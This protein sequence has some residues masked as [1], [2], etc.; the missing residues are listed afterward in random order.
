MDTIKKIKTLS[1]AS[2]CMSVCSIGYCAYNF[3]GAITEAMRGVNQVGFYGGLGLPVAVSVAALVL[4][5]MSHMTVKTLELMN[6][7]GE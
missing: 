2:I 5:V 3:N 4:G 1:T 7:E 6:K